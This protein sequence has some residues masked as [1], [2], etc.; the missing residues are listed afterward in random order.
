MDNDRSSNRDQDEQ[1]V[2]APETVADA[3]IIQTPPEFA[4]AEEEARAVIS[5]EI[6]AGTSLWRDAWRRLLRNKLAAFGIAAVVIVALAS[7]L[8]PTL[9]KSSTG[10]SYDFIP[11]DASLTK[12]FAPFQGPDGRFSW[13]H[14]MGTD[15][16]GRD[17]MARVL[18]GGQ[19]SLMVALISTL[20]SLLI[21][22]S[23]GA[24]LYR[25]GG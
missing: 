9:I 14:P 18:S 12:S 20:V 1:Q 8:G 5:G 25:V 7:F 22:V 19:I 24:V 23:Y 2:S 4:F 21:G 17:I 13:T 10:Y 3:P 6:I 11:R 16:V 15:N